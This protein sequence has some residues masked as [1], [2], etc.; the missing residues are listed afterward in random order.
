MAFLSFLRWC[1]PFARINYE[2]KLKDDL[3]ISA[4]K[5]MKN[6]Y[7]YVETPSIWNSTP[8][9]QA[10][11]QMHFSYGIQLH[12]TQHYFKCI[13][14]ILNIQNNF[15]L[16]ITIRILDIN[17]QRLK[18]LKIENEESNALNWWLESW[19][20]HRASYYIWLRST[21]LIKSACR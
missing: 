15:L 19:S 20:F 14:Q 1:T 8:F 17:F 3:K 4:A 7:I 12:S 21:I 5:Y 9:H 16:R 2:G 6:I 10:L 11:F 18:V 13:S